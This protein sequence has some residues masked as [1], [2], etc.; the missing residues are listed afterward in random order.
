MSHWFWFFSIID[1][2]LT[3]LYRSSSLFYNYFIAENGRVKFH[4]EHEFEVRPIL[5]LHYIQGSS[6]LS[7]L[8]TL[9]DGPIETKK[10]V[11]KTRF[12]HLKRKLGYNL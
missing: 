5:K 7:W 10:N 2:Y 3:F 9:T 6:L 4:V 11:F 12:P 8:Y 1:L